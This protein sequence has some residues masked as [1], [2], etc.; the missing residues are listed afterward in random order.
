MI[1]QLLCILLVCC[2]LIA[3]LAIAT[4]I[5]NKRYN[6][7]YENYTTSFLSNVSSKFPKREKVLSGTL[8][9]KDYV[10]SDVQAVDN[11]VKI[12]ENT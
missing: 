4:T 2:I 11:D 10:I 5:V 12:Y 9:T 3:I 7:M 8:P 1:K 6:V